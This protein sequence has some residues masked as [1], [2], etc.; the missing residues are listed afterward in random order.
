MEQPLFGLLNINKP[1]GCTSRDVVNQVA[2]LVRP[3]KV[4][5]AGTLDPLASG[6]LVLC[7]GRATRLV[8][9][10]QQQPKTYRAEFLLGQ[11]SDTDDV[12]GQLTKTSQLSEVCRDDVE[13][14]LPDYLGTIEQIP[15]RFSAVHVQGQRAYKR[16]RRG[17][18]FQITPRQVHVHRLQI[19]AFDFPKFTLEVEC[20]SGTYIRSIGRDLGTALGCGAVMSRLERSQIGAFHLRAAVQIEQLGVVELDEL[21]SPPE[22]AVTNLAHYHC[23][24]AECR[25]IVHGRAVLLTDK[26]DFPQQ[27]ENKHP[28]ALFDSEQKLIALAEHQPDAFRL[29]PRQVFIETNRYD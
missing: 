18:A 10:V 26:N 16:A 8:Q 17:D 7:L 13:R 21:M 3:A 12:T 15:P 6:V 23:S 29:R 28:F 20:G 2:K 11:T 14:I 4:G 5:H 9:Y 27:T 24:A 1:S 19:V 22:M 25:E